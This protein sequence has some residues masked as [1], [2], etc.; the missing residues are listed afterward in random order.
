MS[1]SSGYDHTCALFTDGSARCWGSDVGGQL[2]ASS[3]FTYSAVSPGGSFTC[4]IRADGDRAGRAFCWGANVIAGRMLPPRGLELTAISSGADHAC[5]LQED[6][7]A[8][9]WGNDSGGRTTPP[10]DE[11]FAALDSGAEHTCGLRADGSAICWGRDNAGQLQ[12]PPEETF[13]ALSSGG[14]LTCGLREE[15]EESKEGTVL[16]WGSFWAD[17]GLPVEEQF[18]ALAAGGE[19]ACGLQGDGR[20]VCW[21]RG[22]EEEL[23]VPAVHNFVAISAG[24]RHA[25]GMRANGEV[26]CWGDNYLGQA[27]APWDL[28]EKPAG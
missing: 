14:S 12:V 21:G 2:G 5:G 11:T 9:C 19:F 17:S 1:I 18:T 26:V 3:I 10:K 4:A 24:S 8:V 27:T 13:T 15:G 22:A 23:E 16:C 7:T 20:V 25:C 6:G 28:G